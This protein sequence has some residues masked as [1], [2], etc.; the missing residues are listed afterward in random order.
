M[1]D[2]STAREIAGLETG[3]ARLNR[4]NADLNARIAELRKTVEE[5]RASIE[6][7][8]LAQDRALIE[9]AVESGVDPRRSL[10]VL[11]LPSGELL[12]VGAREVDL[13]RFVANV[14]ESAARHKFD[15]VWELH[16][17]EDEARAIDGV[18]RPALPEPN[19]FAAA[20]VEFPS[21]SLKSKDTIPE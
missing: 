15:L 16:P 11:P 5:R 9:R 8:L 14:R 17:D 12:A 3:I 6:G 13:D 19:G 21:R 10:R 4:A 7:G 2:D 20:A 1:T 18:D